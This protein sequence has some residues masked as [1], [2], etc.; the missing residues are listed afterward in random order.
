MKS[1]EDHAERIECILSTRHLYL[2]PGKVLK[3]ELSK[4]VIIRYGSIKM[5]HSTVT[6]KSTLESKIFSLEKHFSQQKEQKII[7]STQR[8]CEKQYF[9]FNHLEKLLSEAQFH[10]HKC[11]HLKCVSVQNSLQILNDLMKRYKHPYNLF[12]ARKLD[13][14]KK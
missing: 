14:H 1:L 8:C 11:Q 6:S 7:K 10:V 13:I 4:A 5:F 12:R 2:Q 9:R 3:K